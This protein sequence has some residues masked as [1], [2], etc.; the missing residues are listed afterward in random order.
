MD[1]RV[2]P[3]RIVQTQPRLKRTCR[4]QGSNAMCSYPGAPRTLCGAGET[5]LECIEPDATLWNILPIHYGPHAK[6]LEVFIFD[7]NF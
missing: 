5:R 3:L 1:S 4:A 7:N 6:D 2:F